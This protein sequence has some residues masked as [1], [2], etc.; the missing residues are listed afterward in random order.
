MSDRAEGSVVTLSDI[1]AGIEV[2]DEQRDRGVATVDDTDSDLAE[3][4]SE[5]ESELPTSAT[6]AATVLESFSGGASV[7]AAAR[8]AGLVPV[9]AAK[10]LH[11]LGVDG[12]SPLGPTGRRIVRDWIAGELSHAEARELAGASERAFAL[13]GYV[14]SHDPIEGASE[15]VATARASSD[16][17]AVEKRDR[18][19]GA[20]SDPGQFL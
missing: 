20:L 6:A 9:E 2:V 1:A 7:G 15:A 8:E 14:E 18:L 4:L 19:S 3:S 10:T 13:A 5:F 12:V 17:A 11:R 16:N